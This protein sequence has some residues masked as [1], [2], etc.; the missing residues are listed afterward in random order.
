MELPNVE[1]IE[2]KVE[3]HE[4]KIDNSHEINSNLQLIK[5]DEQYNMYLKGLETSV[6]QYKKLYPEKYEK[7]QSIG[8]D[9]M[10]K[11]YELVPGEDIKGDLLK[12]KNILISVLQYGLEISDLFPDEIVLLKK[13][14][15]CVLNISKDIYDIIINVE[16]LESI[17]NQITTKLDEYEN[18]Y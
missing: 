17:I 2:E 3:Q 14:M 4:E 15:T 10:N 6:E 8:D 18:Y 11:K 9:M 7:A 12:C 16:T 5:T 1:N 13:I